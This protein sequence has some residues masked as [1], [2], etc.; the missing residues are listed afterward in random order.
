MPQKFKVLEKVD[1]AISPAQSETG[2]GSIPAPGSG[3]EEI[4]HE[5]TTMTT[6]WIIYRSAS[7]GR[8]N[9]AVRQGRDAVNVTLHNLREIIKGIDTNGWD[10]Q[11]D[12]LTRGVGGEKQPTKE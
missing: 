5:I 2:P 7:T 1:Q 3:G 10:R 9:I 12:L 8:V 4:L 11:N 6:K